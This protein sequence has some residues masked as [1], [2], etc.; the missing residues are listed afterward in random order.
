LLTLSNGS[1]INATVSGDNVT[2]VAH[3]LVNTWIGVGYGTS[4][5]DTD[6]VIWA[7]GASIDAS[8]VYDVYSTSSS[9][10]VQDTTNIYTTTMELNGNFI[11][12]TSVRPLTPPSDATQA[13]VITLDL[14]TPMIWAWSTYDS[15]KGYTGVNYHSSNYSGTNSW[16]VTFNSGGTVTSTG[17]NGADTIITT[18]SLLITMANGSSLSANYTPTS[19]VTGYGATSG[20]TITYTVNVL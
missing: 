13:Y 4:M 12:F 5:T 16:V 10:P 7:A 19:S 15:S 8:S 9:K 20:D 17:D 6:E 11:D 2:Y 1:T 18:P 14:A 3:V